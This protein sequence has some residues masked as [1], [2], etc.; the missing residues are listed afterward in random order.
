M[1]RI[2]ENIAMKLAHIFTLVLGLHAAVIA[3]LFVTPGCASDPGDAASAAATEPAGEPAREQESAP[4]P[5][6]EAIERSPDS[7]VKRYPPTRPAWNLNET[8]EAEVIVVAEETPM[9]VETVEEVAVLEPLTPPTAA[10]NAVP[11]MSSKT[12]IVKKGDNLSTIARQHGVTLGEVMAAN[13]FTRETANRLKIG[14]AIQV[15]VS[16]DDDA[17]APAAA[18]APRYASASV[19]EEGAAY[20]VRSGDTLSAIAKR[21]QST[22]RAIASANNLS[23]DRIVVGQ[24]LLIPQVE[25]APAPV[26]GVP[27]EVGEVVYEVEPGDTL[28]AIAKRY[29]VSVKT[30]MQAN[31]VTDPRRLRV[32][33]RLV[34][35]TD[36]QPVT[37]LKPKP[38][39]PLAPPA[40]VV[41]EEAEVI[42]ETSSLDDIDLDAIPAVE[43]E[44]AE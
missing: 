1:R 2:V 20:T 35:P 39:A 14:Q 9:V 34:I 40:P 31:G 42:E 24:Q 4:Y 36:M 28:G 7:G 32:G 11:S 22:V 41:I 18:E 33:Q 30:I 26:L 29:D 37:P 16:A 25:Q 43:V 6:A 13:G 21:H 17:P 27:N 23:G 8:T 19:G 5:V 15:P 3:A 44:P 12:Y 38:A 10:F